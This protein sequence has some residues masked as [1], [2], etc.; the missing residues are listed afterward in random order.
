MLNSK[1]QIP[2]HKQITNPNYRMTKIPKSGFGIVILKLYIVC[3]LCIGICDF[4]V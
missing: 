2:N 4:N 1:S 3:D